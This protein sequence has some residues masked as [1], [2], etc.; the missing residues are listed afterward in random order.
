MKIVLYIIYLFLCSEVSIQVYLVMK[1][2]YANALMF[3]LRNS[4]TRTLYRTP[5]FT[6]PLNH[7]GVFAQ[8]LFQLMQPSVDK[9]YIP[10][11]VLYEIEAQLRGKR[12][13]P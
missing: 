10:Y 7:I 6:V 13:P 3:P 5:H 2:D 4:I 12:T 9:T 1:V 11:I 8:V